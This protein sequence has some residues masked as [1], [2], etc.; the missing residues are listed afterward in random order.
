MQTCKTDGRAPLR[1]CQIRAQVKLTY[2]AD[3]PMPLRPCETAALRTPTQAF[4]TDAP[5]PP[6]CSKSFNE[7]VLPPIQKLPGEHSSR[8]YG[9]TEQEPPATSQEP[10]E[11]P[12]EDAE[13]LDEVTCPAFRRSA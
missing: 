2:K 8:L 5:E 13:D 9:C 7:Q 3:A 4:E 11:V 12:Q 6:R 10:E 1:P